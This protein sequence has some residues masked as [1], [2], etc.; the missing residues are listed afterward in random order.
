MVAVRGGGKTWIA[1]RF[2]V[3][4]I[5]KDANTFIR[6]GIVQKIPYLHSRTLMNWTAGAESVGLKAR[7]IESKAR[8]KT[9]T[10]RRG[11]MVDVG[12]K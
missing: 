9:L 7:A 8:T 3:D 4:S 12:E 11:F 1:L 5:V 6:D 10:F 2:R